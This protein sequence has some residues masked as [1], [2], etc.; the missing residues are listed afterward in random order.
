MNDEAMICEMKKVIDKVNNVK[1]HVTYEVCHD[2]LFIETLKFRTVVAPMFRML[3]Q[4]IESIG[5][6]LMFKENLFG[7]DTQSYTISND[8]SSEHE[9]EVI[10]NVGDT[11]VIVIVDATENTLCDTLLI[12]YRSYRGDV[13]ESDSAEKNEVLLISAKTGYVY[14]VDDID[15]N[16]DDD[17]A[18]RF[19]SNIVM[20]IIKEEQSPL[21]AFS[22][23]NRNMFDESD[24]DEMIS[25]FNDAVEGIF[26]AVDEV[27]DRLTEII[28][29]GETDNEGEGS[30]EHG[31]EEEGSRSVRSGKSS[32]KRAPRVSKSKA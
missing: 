17:V 24:A 6:N 1:K 15:A 32:S 27:A 23:E 11:D 16:A 28:D 31:N 19:L 12:T 13:P 8:G 14:A 26:K 5:G 10:V 4:L 2:N 25:E 30:N 18:V 29:L 21:S 20:S 7:P 3:S 9:Y 22:S